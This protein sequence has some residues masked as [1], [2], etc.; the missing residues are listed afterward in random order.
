M[1]NDDLVLIVGRSSSVVSR[2]ETVVLLTNR[3]VELEEILAN[4]FGNE[5]LPESKCFKKGKYV[6]HG[7][8]EWQLALN[9]IISTYE[10]NKTLLTLAT[11]ESFIRFNTPTVTPINKINTDVLY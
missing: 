11:D 10:L 7:T 3:I 2:S 9:D 8:E 1:N 6:G 5:H 4:Q